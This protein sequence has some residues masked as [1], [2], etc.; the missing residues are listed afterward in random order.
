MDQARVMDV[1]A[2]EGIHTDKIERDFWYLVPFLVF[3]A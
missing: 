1:I 3:G 2:G